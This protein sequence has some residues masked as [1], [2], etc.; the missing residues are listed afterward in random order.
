MRIIELQDHLL[1]TYDRAI[2]EYTDKQFERA[3]I[4][5]VLNSRV[6]EVCGQGTGKG[7]VKVKGPDGKETEI[8]FGACVWSTGVAMHPLVKQLQPKL[9]S[10]AQTHFR[11]VV[12]TPWLEVRK[13][14]VF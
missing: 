10:G 3:G 2:S 6:L 5:L 1:S 12:T 13:K 4:E 14:I 7:F 11:S 9:A 8:P